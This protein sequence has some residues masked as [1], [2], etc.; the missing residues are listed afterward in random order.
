M[1]ATEAL[2]DSEETGYGLTGR[3][4]RVGQQEK[5]VNQFL[6]AMVSTCESGLM[7]NSVQG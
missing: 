3:T 7:G 2:G 5:R 6:W 4:W 1:R